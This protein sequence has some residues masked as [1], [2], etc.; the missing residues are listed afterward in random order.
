M[1]SGP[2]GVHTPIP[3]THTRAP[4][5]YTVTSPNFTHLLYR[6]Y[7]PHAIHV[8]H[9]VQHNNIILCTIRTYDVPIYN[10]IPVVVS[11]RAQTDERL[12]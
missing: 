3:Y 1:R 12:E 6:Y 5:P 2:P 4:D 9:N 11:G 8:V 10:I 7:I